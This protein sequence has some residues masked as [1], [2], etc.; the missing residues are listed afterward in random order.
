MAAETVPDHGASLHEGRGEIDARHE[1]TH[2][3]DPPV[4]EGNPAHPD[5]PLLGDSAAG[6]RGEQGPAL[7]GIDGAHR[8][9]LA[10]QHP[11]T[12]PMHQPAVLARHADAEQLD[13]DRRSSARSSPGLRMSGP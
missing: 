6:D 9:E 3:G 2:P 4:D 7:G 5:P 1:L 11:R 10:A 12:D 8:G 13:H